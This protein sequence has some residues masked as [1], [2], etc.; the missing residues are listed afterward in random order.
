M[1]LLAR[2]LWGH[3]VPVA[4][5]E[6][7]PAVWAA[8]VC[9]FGNVVCSPHVQALAVEHVGT[10]QCGHFLPHVDGVLADGT[11]VRVA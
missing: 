1:V 3:G 6:R 10:R 7:A 4:L 11:E 5:N 9:A 8:C 2:G